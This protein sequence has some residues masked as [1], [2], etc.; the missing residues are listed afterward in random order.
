VRNDLLSRVR[1][2]APRLLRYSVYAES[3]SMDNTPATFAWYVAG[4]VQKAL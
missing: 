1:S 2:T 4:L 3:K